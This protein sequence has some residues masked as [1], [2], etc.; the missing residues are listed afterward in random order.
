MCVTTLLIDS[1]VIQMH[2]S[3]RDVTRAK[4]VAMLNIQL[5]T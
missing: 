5:A 1:I 3:D 4:V 2:I